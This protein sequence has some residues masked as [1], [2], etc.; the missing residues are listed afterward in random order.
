MNGYR[1][2]I[3]GAT[4]LVG[5]EMLRLLIQRHF[6]ISSLKLLASDR[7]A[8]TMVALGP[9]NYQ[10]ELATPDSFCGVDLVLSSAGE[11]ISRELVPVAV[12]AGAVVI[13]NT[14]EFRMLATVPLCIPEINASAARGHRGIIANPNCSAAIVLVALAP[15]Q[16][17]GQLQRI[18]VS[19]YQSVAGAG[20][21]AVQELES[22]TR[23]QITDQPLSSTVFPKPIAFNLLPA[24]GSFRA[25]GYTSEEVKMTSEMRKILDLPELRVSCTCVRVP[26]KVG[27]SAAV[28]VEFDRPVELSAVRACLTRAPGIH[29]MDE[30]ADLPTPMDCAGRDEVLVGRIRGDLSHPNGLNFWVCGDNLRKGAALNAIQIAEVL[31]QD[32]LLKS[33]GA[34]S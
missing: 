32:G 24:I 1:L 16:A 12:K 6:P 33:P 13:D 9:R 3:L 4:G 25:D 23:A 15:L 5:Q 11:Q 18:V 26:I 21:E 2:A 34:I 28:N 7:S 31:L 22:Q 30:P 19:T 17:L 20:K 14:A 29:V 27:H 10:V 8:G